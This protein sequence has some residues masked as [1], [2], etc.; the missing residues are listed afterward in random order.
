VTEPP[1]PGAIFSRE[2][3]IRVDRDGRFWHDGARVDHPGVARAFASWIDVDPATGRYVLRNQINWCYVTV[4]DAPLVVRSVEIDPTGR[5]QLHLSDGATEALDG[6]TLR[7]DEDDVPYCD[8]RGG[9]LPARFLP[10]AA[11]A[12]LERLESTPAGPRLQGVLVRR[13]ARGAGSRRT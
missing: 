9:R 13:V 1:P 7:L 8:V 11:F 6:A 2:S 10:Q 4:E 3:T 5:M 12:L